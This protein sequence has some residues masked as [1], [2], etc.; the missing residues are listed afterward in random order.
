MYG[1]LGHIG[2]P[3]KDI[4]I[5]RSGSPLFG[6]NTYGVHMTLFM[7]TDNGLKI[8]VPRRAKTKQTYG[9]MLDNSVAGGLAIGESPFLC[10]L[11][12]A[13]EEASLPEGLVKARAKAC[14]TVSYIHVR[15]AQAGGESG[16]FQPECQ[17]CYDME[18]GDI[19]PK[20][21][22]TEVEA[23]Y[24]WTVDEVKQH[25][26]KGEFKPNC[27]LVLLDFFVRHGII[28]AENEPHYIEIV[29]RLHRR[30]PF[31]SNQP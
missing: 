20:P 13:F 25:L 17:F 7:K 27:A 2:Q 14:G 15:D 29:S 6:I 8:W 31:P 22:D 3:E 21:N 23:F 26:A 9:G 16:L 4:G 19:Q 1:I 11:R 18:L 12:E 24:L 30:L 10:L 5:E 28:T